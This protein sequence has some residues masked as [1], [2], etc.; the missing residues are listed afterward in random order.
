MY[1]TIVLTLIPILALSQAPV[2]NFNIR[3]DTL[4]LLASLNF[5]Q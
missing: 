5:K 2:T 3:L 1:L 4:T